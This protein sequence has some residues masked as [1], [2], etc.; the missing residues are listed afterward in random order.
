MRNTK[1]Q[2]YVIYCDKKQQMILYFM[3]HVSLLVETFS[4]HANETGYIK[5]IKTHNTNS[6]RFLKLQCTILDVH[7]YGTQKQPSGCVLR[8]T[9]SENMQQIYRRTAMP[10][11]IIVLL[12]I[13][14]DGILLIYACRCVKRCR[15]IQSVSILI[16]N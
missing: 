7:V 8:K 10:G 14:H 15:I 6:I 2:R 3:K 9:C 12:G 5:N 11:T 4:F 1:W 13:I 16:K